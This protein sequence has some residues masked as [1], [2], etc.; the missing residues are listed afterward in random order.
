VVSFDP[1]DVAPDDRW[2]AA[3]CGPPRAVFVVVYQAGATAFRRRR[4]HL[5]QPGGGARRSGY[6]RQRTIC[7]AVGETRA[8]QARLARGRAGQWCAAV[9]VLH[10]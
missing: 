9:S 1:A 2:K 4:R 5:R 3:T 6:R 7:V 10:R 8:D